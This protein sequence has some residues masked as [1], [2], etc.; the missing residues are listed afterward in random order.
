MEPQIPYIKR[1]I[2]AYNIPFIEKEG[3]EADDVIGTIAK[4]VAEKGV[5]VVMVTGD[6]DML[7]LV[8]EHIRTLDTSRNRFLG[9][10]EVVERSPLASARVNSDFDGMFTGW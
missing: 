8:D 7:Q 10:K 2:E 4:G 9:P 1:I 5:D 6:K 3:Y